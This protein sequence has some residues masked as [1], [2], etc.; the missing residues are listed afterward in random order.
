ML[1]IIGL[2]N[3]GREYQKTRHNTGFMFVDYWAE[4]EKLSWRNDKFLKSAITGREGLVLVKPSTFMNKSGTA[5]KMI[6]D[7][8]NQ[9]KLNFTYADQADGSLHFDYV[10]DTIFGEGIKGIF[11]DA[12]NQLLVVHDELD[13]RLGEWKL[14]KSKSSPLH[15]GVSS[16]E[17]CLKAKDFWRLRIGVDNRLAEERI[18]G[19]KYVLQPFTKDELDTLQNAFAKMLEKTA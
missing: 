12:S 3:P 19:E 2:G 17:D 18:P 4:K 13:L 9:E 7:K 6:I 10:S 16:I 1:T 8:I 11:S 14:N 15:K 5:V